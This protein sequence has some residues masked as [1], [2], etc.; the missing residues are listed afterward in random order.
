F[1]YNTFVVGVPVTL[2]GDL[3][4]QFVEANVGFDT[5]CKVNSQLTSNVCATSAQMPFLQR[6]HVI[7]HPFLCIKKLAVRLMDWNWNTPTE[8]DWENLTKYNKKEIEVPKNL[9]FSIHESQANVVVANVDF[10]FS[11]STDSSSKGEIKN[12]EVFDDLRK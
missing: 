8:W 11:A 5:I 10:A 1:S 6:S 4:N 12:F 9:Q 3:K 7:R 2:N